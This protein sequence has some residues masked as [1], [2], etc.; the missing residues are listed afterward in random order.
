[1]L[2]F[3]KCCIITLKIK[4]MLGESNMRQFTRLDVIQHALKNPMEDFF[5][6][7]DKKVVINELI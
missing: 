2:F 1:M 3:L 6:N 4:N 7:H 5:Y